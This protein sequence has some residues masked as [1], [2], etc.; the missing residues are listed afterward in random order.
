MQRI[1]NQNK[2]KVTHKNHPRKIS[3]M[4]ADEKKAY[5]RKKQQERRSREKKRKNSSKIR[6]RETTLKSTSVKSEELPSSSRA[7]TYR[8]I[9]R[10][11]TAMP[12]SP[13]TYATVVNKLIDNATPRKVAA[14]KSQAI[15][16]KLYQPDLMSGVKETVNKFKSVKGQSK[17]ASLIAI[18][19]VCHTSG[20]KHRKLSKSGI[21]S[22]LYTHVKQGK[23]IRKKRKDS[24]LSQPTLV[25][26]V[27]NHWYENSREM[28]LHK[29]VKKQKPLFLLESTYMAS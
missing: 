29:R 28:P 26:K 21:P 22:R 7:T 18:A 19:M 15:K 2:M 11:T 25:D 17:Y 9:K 3:E 20:V 27:Q 5:N 12:S 24:M 8:S 4:S 16:C 14:L 6:S 10:A 1:V 13:N 23:E